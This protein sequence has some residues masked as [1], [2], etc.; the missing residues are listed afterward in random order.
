MPESTRSLRLLSFVLLVI[1]VV[2]TLF[3]IWFYRLVTTPVELPVIPCEFSIE[4]RGSL[5]NIAQQ[6]TNAD[7]LPNA[8]SFILLA[9]MT[10]YNASL[11]AGEYE[12]TQNLSPL[13]LL[14]YLTQG[15]V[16]QHTITFLEGWTFSQFRKVLDEHPA[17]H[18]V[19]SE[20]SNLKLLE[21][22]GAK[23]PGVEGIFFPDTYFFTKNSS[24]LTILK[25]AYHAM[26][27]HLETEWISRQK[28]LPLKNQY[29]G[30]ILASIIEKETG[31]DNERAWIAGVFVNRLRHNMKL[32]TDPTVIYGMGD[33]FGGNLRKIDLQTDHAYN[34]YTRPG[35]PPTPIAM[36][37]LAS[38]RAAFN[39]AITDKLY[40]VAKGDGTSHFSSTLEEHNRAVLKYQKNRP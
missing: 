10:G 8:W 11:K 15:R 31:R 1:L 2:S 18:H 26:Q 40:F 29:E 21:L 13:D 17:I 39:P 23:E 20:F 32:Q 16:K 3:S 35:L 38:I 9:H 4:P 25:R 30:L 28:S 6:L 12:L 22:I 36:P 7:I 27:R 34:T 19:S 37:G 14:E 5:R 33:K 24:D